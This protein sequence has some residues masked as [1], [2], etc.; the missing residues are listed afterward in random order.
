MDT[1][2]RITTLSDFQKSLIV[3]ALREASMADRPFIPSRR[4]LIEL[5][6]VGKVEVTTDEPNGEVNH[7]RSYRYPKND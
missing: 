4:E 6:H 7:D 5:F 3:S 1:F 2:K